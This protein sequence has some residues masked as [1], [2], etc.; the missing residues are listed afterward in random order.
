[1]DADIPVT[2]DEFE[3]TAKAIY[4]ETGVQGA[5]IYKNF[6]GQYFAG[7]FGTFAKFTTAPDLNYP[8]YQVDETVKFAPLT[9][10]YRE[11]MTKMQSWYQDGII[12]KDYYTYNNPGDLE[13]IIL[14]GEC[15]VAMGNGSEFETRMGQTDYEFLPMA[16]L[17][18]QPG[19]VIHTGSAPYQE[20]DLDVGRVEVITTQCENLDLVLSLFNFAFSEEGSR[21]ASYGIEGE[22]FTYDENGQPQLT[23]LILNDEELGTMHALGVHLTTICA[24]T[25]ESRTASTVTDYQKECYDVWMS[26]VDDAYTLD[27]SVLALTTEEADTINKISG[28]IVTYLEEANIQFITGARNTQEDYDAFV[29]DLTDMGIDD[30]I[31]AYQAAYERYLQR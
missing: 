1:M 31:A 3:Q 26:N 24:L 6:F 21:I 29:S 8:F 7:G 27:T 25:D 4:D 17:V 16:D 9:E 10:E 5:L 2:Y 22:T 15:A 13:G 11:Y 18:K 12:Y 14:A 30:M 28:D 23:E 20:G 19:D